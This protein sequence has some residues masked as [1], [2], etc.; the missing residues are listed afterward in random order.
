MKSLTISE[1]A[2]ADLLELAAFIAA[3]QPLAAHRF[4]DEALDALDLLQRNPH[5]GRVRQ[6]SAYD[7]EVRLWVLPK[8]RFCIIAYHVT[9][10]SVHVIR[11]LHAA[12]DFNTIFD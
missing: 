8:H 2:R 4:L 1:R 6:S 5:L 11:V 3:D 10:A 7:V 12:R 9:S